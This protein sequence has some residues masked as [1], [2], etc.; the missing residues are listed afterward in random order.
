MQRYL[1]WRIGRKEYAIALAT[2]FAAYF[3]VFFLVSTTLAQMVLPVIWVLVLAVPRLRDIGWNPWWALAP[4]GAGFAVGFLNAV[5]ARAAGQPWPIG[6]LLVMVVG[7]G[8][9]AFM[10]LLAFKRSKVVLADVF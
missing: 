10:V 9:L 3:A 7:L 8:S 4:F 2:Y 6:G 1:D 5:V